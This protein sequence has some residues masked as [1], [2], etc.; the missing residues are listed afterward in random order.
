MFIRLSFFLAVAAYA[1]S[2]AGQITGLV[3]D[4]T[5]AAVPG[6]ALE[7]QNVDTGIS[8]TGQTNEQ[9]AYRF[10]FL[11]PGVYRVRVE[12]QGFRAVNRSNVRLQVD[13]VAQLDFALEVG[14]ASEAITVEAAAPL[15][16]QSTS[17][18][19]QVIDNS[20]I[21]NIPLNG[22]SSFRLVQLTP[23]VLNAPS[24]NGQ[25]G[26]IPVNT[27]DESIISIN[28][29]RNKTNEIMIDGVPSTTGF[30]NVM[31]TIPSV[32]A[33]EE[34]KVQ[35]SNLS[36]EWGRFGGGVI[37]VSTKSGT[38]E[39]HGTL[40]EFLRNSVLD[41][42]EFFNKG[43]GRAIPPFR[44]NQY[45]FALGGPV[46]K[47]RTFFFADVQGTKWRKGDIFIASL[48]TALQ[49]AGDFSQTLTAA[50]QRI[51]VYDPQTTRDN[52]AVPGRLV[53]DAFPGNVVPAAR[54]DPVV[55][56]MMTFFPQPNATGV[57][58]TQANNFVSNAPRKIDQI[59]YSARGDHNVSSSH[60]VFGRFS[61]LR[62]TIFQPDS[63]GNAAT[64]G[65]GANGNLNLY[66]YS[67]SLD[68][69]V[70]LTPTAIL[71][72]RYG[73]ARFYW[74]RPTRSFGFNQTELGLPQSLVGQFQSHR[75][76]GRFR[77]HVRQ[78]GFVHGAGHP[79]SAGLPKQGS[80]QPYP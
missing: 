76:R 40:F 14:S 5:G 71:T 9:G 53:R 75:E 33:T 44:M 77:F 55:R 2:T 41:S 60:R 74:G 49:R 63:F 62:S 38:N 59:N 48:P 57:P 39:F 4:A 47:N 19:G 68:N 23:G 31:T 18:L 69:T 64:S 13:Q 30:V 36:A 80:S 45:G 8:H 72:V 42:N 67:A 66:N 46:V 7:V 37:N 65:P 25:F 52:P 21:S 15:L 58:L 50:N 20:K 1:Q 3:T 26:D 22:R 29:G 79:Q 16:E 17:A 32:D 35:S 43:A 12:K 24:A 51:L 11:A 34:F 61:V 78:L 6:A 56:R 70:T 28:G 27:M 10:P 54:I 73:F